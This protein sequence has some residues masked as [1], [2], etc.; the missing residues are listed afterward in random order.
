MAGEETKPRELDK[1][2]EL[3]YSEM[4]DDEIELV[5]E[6]KAECKLREAEHAA[7]MEALETATKVVI[8]EHHE[9]AKRSS[10]MLDDLAQQAV[11]RLRVIESAEG[12]G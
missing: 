10:R 1:L 3:E 6:W 12:N 5:L 8:E 9:V 7:F 2:L 4:S 11:E